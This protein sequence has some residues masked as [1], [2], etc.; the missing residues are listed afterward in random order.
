[1]SWPMRCVMNVL[2]LAVTAS[3]VTAAGNIACVVEDRV[4]SLSLNAPF[5]PD[6]QSYALLD[7]SGRVAIKYDDIPRDAGGI[8]LERAA[9]AQYWF[10]GRN[11]KLRIYRDTQL[12]DQALSVEII[13]VLKQVRTDPTTYRGRYFLKERHRDALK[14]RRDR[15]NKAAGYAECSVN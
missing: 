3:D 14:S 15:I 6:G 4:L 10:D 7:V 1:M 12:G 8:E 11:L 13:L 2:V 5:D 9:V